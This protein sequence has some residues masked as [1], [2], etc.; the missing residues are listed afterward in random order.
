MNELASGDENDNLNESQERGE[1]GEG[2]DQDYSELMGNTSK[3]RSKIGKA[4]SKKKE[5]KGFQFAAWD[6]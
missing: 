5:D 4:G 1:A 6:F 2:A 3:Q